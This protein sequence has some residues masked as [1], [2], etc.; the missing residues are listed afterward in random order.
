L[1]ENWKSF[2]DWLSESMTRL[3]LTGASGFLGS[4]LAHHWVASGHEVHA[5]VRPTSDLRRIV[6]IREQVVLHRAAS[7]QEAAQIIGQVSPDTIVH[8]ACVY[9]RSGE[10]PYQ[11]FEA[12]VALGAAILQAVLD[13]GRKVNFINSGSVLEPEVSLYALSKRQFCDWGARLAEQS[14]DLLRFVDLRMQHMYGAGD[15]AS[16]FTTRVLRACLTGSP[17]LR[18]TAGEQER[19]FIYIDD[20]V[21]AFDTVLATVDQMSE[22]ESIEVGSGQAQRIRAFV[23][24]VHDLTRASTKLLFGATPYRPNEAMRCVADTARLRSLGWR[25]AYSLRSG[26][27]ETIRRETG[28]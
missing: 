21:S 1:S 27:Q 26:L 19:D 14:P 23:E 7:A 4:A 16:K 8:T 6:A 10:S 2:S 12:N 11:V 28:S 3:L 22:V 25:P 24:L 5:V 20:V 13:G 15:D 17:E 9:G 18:L